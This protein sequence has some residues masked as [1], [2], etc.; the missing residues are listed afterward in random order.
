[1]R[2]KTTQLICTYVPYVVEYKL[3]FQTQSSFA[4]NT[5]KKLPPKIFVMFS[6]E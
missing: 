6:L 1:M 5:R 4:F 3:E 2:V